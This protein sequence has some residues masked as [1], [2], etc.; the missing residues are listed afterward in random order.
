MAET[1][2]ITGGAGFIG[3]HLVDAYLRAGYRVRVFDNLDPQ[4]HGGLR[5]RGGCPDY[6]SRDA[7]FICGD[8][9]DRSAMMK[10][11]QGVTLVSHHAAAVGVGQSMY[12]IEHYASVNAYGAAV[13]L[14]V[15][16]NE[17]LPVRRMLA[18]SSMSVYGEGAYL[19][20]S[21]GELVSPEL[22][23]LKQLE[24][25]QWEVQDENGEVLSPVVTREDKTLRPA[26]VYAINKR[27]HEDMFLTVGAAY[28]I[29]TVVFRY[30]NVFGP[31]QALSN[32]YTGVAAIFAGRLL[33]QRPPLV[34]EDGQ[35]RRDFVS[36]YDVAEANVLATGAEGLNYAVVNIGSGDFINILGI[37][38]VLADA[39]GTPIHPEIIGKYR[40]GDIRHCYA[41]ISRAKALLGWCP[42]HNFRDSAV[43][44]V[45]WV[46]RQE[47]VDKVARMAQ[48]L[49]TRGLVG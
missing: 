31:R 35:Q 6:L 33:N 10:A 18:A 3:S 34:F 16:V 42:R 8:I 28:R 26:S 25:R 1:V 13:L 40:L 32:P 47:A 38:Q 2:L 7:E 14:D 48:E 30:F 11:L 20:P 22:R 4:V 5:E 45:E 39:M 36:V 23:S 15:I 49:E 37:A 17:R 9:R 12:Q 24:R 43:A 29:P 46:M 19:R 27:D 44:L 21:T 41:D